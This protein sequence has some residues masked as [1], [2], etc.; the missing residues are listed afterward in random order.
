MEAAT[1]SLTIDMYIHTVVPAP[2]KLK[3]SPPRFKERIKE[4]MMETI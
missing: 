3:I 2:K 4:K 1:I